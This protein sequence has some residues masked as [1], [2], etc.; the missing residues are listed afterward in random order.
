MLYLLGV[1]RLASQECVGKRTRKGRM[2]GA[3][4]GVSY[5]HSEEEQESWRAIEERGGER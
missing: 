3:C 4:E 1:G 5:K 2:T